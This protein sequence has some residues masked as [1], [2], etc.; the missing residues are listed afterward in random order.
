MYKIARLVS[1]LLFSLPMIARGM[2]V[3]ELVTKSIQAKGGLD[4]IKAIQSMRMTGQLKIS[5][6]SFSLDMKYLQL[7]Q[8]GGF[9]RNEA[10]LQGLTAITAY[11]GKEGWTLSPFEGRREP[12]KMSADQKKNLEEESD[13]D[14]PLV[15]Y[16]T[17]GHQLELL[18][19]EDVDGTD[20][21]KLKVTLKNGDVKYIYLDP[22]YFLEIRTL[23]QSKVRGVEVEQETDLGNYEQVNGIYMPFSIESG[24][25]GGP[26]SQ[27]ITIERVE[28]NV[29]LDDKLFHFPQESK[30]SNPP[31]K[32]KN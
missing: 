8:R 22:D 2:T 11:D 16:Q 9:Y 19:R 24:S 7:N 12:E 31:T 28:V 21:Y 32:E 1:L 6:D 14:G 15:D 20:A 23:S 17:K 25:K 18:G 27:K 10:S 5:G 30:S 29:D 4:K 26:K 13:F 3:E